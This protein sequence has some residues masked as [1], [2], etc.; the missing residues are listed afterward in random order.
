MW[1]RRPADVVDELEK[2]REAIPYVLPVINVRQN[3]IEESQSFPNVDS[4]HLIRILNE[5]NYS[6]ETGMSPPG[7]LPMPEKVLQEQMA[8]LDAMVTFIIFVPYIWKDIVLLFLLLPKGE[9]IIKSNIT[10][11]E[12]QVQLLSPMG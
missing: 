1:L 7:R 3:S 9:K 8:A 6:E 11:A 4:F 5:Q 10:E 2:P 12:R